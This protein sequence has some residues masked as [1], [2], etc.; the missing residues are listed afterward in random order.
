MTLNY[1]R[2]PFWARV[3]TAWWVLLGRAMLADYTESTDAK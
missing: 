2:M 3:R 1:G